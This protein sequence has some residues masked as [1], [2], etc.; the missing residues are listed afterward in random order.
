MKRALTPASTLFLVAALAATTATTAATATAAAPDASF[1]DLRWRLLGP[2]RAGWSIV[3]EGIAGEID[4]YYF[5]AADGGVWK[6]DDSGVTWRP[7]SDQAPFSSVGGL[8]IASAPKGG[9]TIWVGSGQTQTRYDVMDG[10][11]VW[12]STDEGA[13]WSAMGLA[14]SRHI[15]RIWVDPRDP[16]VVLVAALGHLFGPSPE[17]GVY[18][19]TDGG[20]SWTRVAFADESTGAVDLA[21]DRETPD[22]VYAAFW[23]T[24]MFPWQ[25]YHVPQIGPGSGIWRSTD[26]G[27]NWSAAPRT[28]LPEGPLGK[29]GLAV[30]PKTG[31]K[32]VYAAID[33]PKAAGLYR[34]NDGGSTWALAQ[35]NRSLSSNYFGRIF[36]DPRDPDVVYFTGQSF[37][38]STDGGKT[39]RYIKGSPGGDDYHF[40]W[41]NPERPERMI[42]ASDQGTTVSVNGGTTWSPWYNQPTGQFYRL[43]VDD[44]F[45]YRVYSGQQDCGTVSVASRSDYGQLTF[46]DW[47]PVGGDE[48][49][50]DLPDPTD[51]N[52]VYGSGLGGKLSRWDARTGR[53]ANVSPWPISSY[54]QRPPSVPNRTTWITPIAIDPRSPHAL[55][56]GTQALHRSL[57]RGQSWQTISPDLTGAVPNAPGCAEPGR[58]D[59]PVERATACGYGVIFS[60]APSRVASGLI[61]VGTD[62][63]RI[64]LTKDGGLT[65]ANVTPKD[66]PDWSSVAQID[67]GAQAG[68]AYVAIDRHRLN[69]RDPRVYVTHDFG[70]TWRRADADLPAG[71]WVNVVRADPERPGLLYAGTRIGVFVSFD[72][73]AHWAPLQLNLPRTGV[74]DLLVKGRDLVIATQGRALWVLD[75]VTPLRAEFSSSRAAALAKPGTAIRLAASENRDTPLPPEFPT[76]PNP[77]AGVP[78]DYLLPSAPSGPVT[79]EILDAAGAL[80]RRF[81]S[82]EAPE[83]PEARQY[84][85]DRWLLPPAVPTAN[86]GHNRFWWDLRHPQPKA[87]DYDFSIAAIPG[88]D[89]PTLPQGMLVLPGSYRIRLGADG[90]TLEQPLIVQ[91]DP[92]SPATAEDLAAGFAFSREVG[93]TLAQTVEAIAQINT[94]DAKLAPLASGERKAAKRLAERAKVTRDGLAQ[95]TGGGGETDL[96]AVGAILSGLLGDL[97]GADS[98]PTSPQREILAQMRTRLERALGL[99]RELRGAVGEQFGKE[100]SARAAGSAGA[101]RP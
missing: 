19:T 8:A 85:A 40:F 91:K 15:G 20:A 67:A 44:Q 26:G 13:T 77:P 55:Y 31:G 79:I 5:G 21:V 30:A 101:D 52:L 46:R 95:L 18:R 99:W 63:G 49:D 59:P 16:N 73:G 96:S 12:K 53:V 33:A 25:G 87:T 28:G 56:Q 48:R 45:P 41:L 81:S 2:L 71:A 75:D 57:D 54:G 36:T 50:G 22:V 34:S 38:K 76:T 83:R 14:D 89:T 10:N 47:H 24:R 86:V 62:N 64:Q 29:I 88:R 65:W 4:T 94:F 39:F 7:L 35:A 51:P 3:A 6:T 23:Q 9:R 32:R 70:A 80:V 27:K 92:R 69:D 17:R 1:Q 74:N 42:L 72:D 43:G 98:P 66:L 11:G 68:S 37:R 90:T 82:A 100:V 78:I 60:I 84:F 58:I 97:E 61:W 93:A